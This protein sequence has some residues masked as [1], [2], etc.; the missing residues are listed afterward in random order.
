MLIVQNQIFFVVSNFIWLLKEFFTIN[1]LLETFQGS[2][3]VFLTFSVMHIC[4]ND[5]LA[6]THFRKIGMKNAMWKHYNDKT[7]QMTTKERIVYAAK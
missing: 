4:A 2:F 6:P 7:L 5:L 3:S 1:N